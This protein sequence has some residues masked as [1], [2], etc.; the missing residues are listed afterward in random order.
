MEKEEGGSGK[1]EGGKEKEERKPFLFP[2]R[3][4]MESYR[5]PLEQKCY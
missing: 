4:L 2:N 5:S 3:I 1:G